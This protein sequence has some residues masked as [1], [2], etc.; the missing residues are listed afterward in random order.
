MSTANTTT[1]FWPIDVHQAGFIYGWT[2]PAL[3]IAGVIQSD[4]ESEAMSKLDSI[5]DTTRWKPLIERWGGRPFVLGRCSFAERV[6]TRHS[7]PGTLPHPILEIRSEFPKSLVLT[8]LSQLQ[9]IYYHRH[10]ATSMRLYASEFPRSLFALQGRS[11][12]TDSHKGHYTNVKENADTTQVS[13]SKLYTYFLLN[14]WNSAKSLQHS[15]DDVHSRNPHRHPS[16]KYSTAWTKR[17]RRFIS[18]VSSYIRGRLN[19]IS[20][21]SLPSY[22]NLSF[23][24]QQLDVRAGTISSLF[25]LSQTLHEQSSA[26]TPSSSFLYIKFY[27]SVWVILNDITVGM[28][29]GTFLCKNRMV[30]AAHLTHVME[31]W[32]VQW[33]Q[34]VLVWLDSWPAG[35]K[36]NTELGRFY[37]HTL[38]GLIAVWN[39]AFQQT[40]PLL[41]GTIGLVGLTSFLGATLAISLAS[42]LLCVLTAHMYVCYRL[43]A[44]VYYHQLQLVGSLWKLFR[45]KRYNALRNRTDT[46][47]YDIDQLLLGTILFT[48]VAYLSPTITLYYALF[49]LLRLSIVFLHAILQTLLAFISHFPLFALM[50]RVKDPWRVPGGI[51]LSPQTKSKSMQNVLVVENCPPTLSAIFFQYAELWTWLARHYHPIQLLR[52]IVTGAFLT[53]VTGSF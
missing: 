7:S 18:T 27:N 53:V 21:A 3:C 12:S 13:S 6:V 32:S 29:L 46:W 5:Q 19:V 47:D 39:T 25:S 23:T 22:R 17:P 40:A 36:L 35:L 16:S 31:T 44:V 42:D 26:V 51:Y 38:I 28:A 43:V 49:A 33:L 1:I 11:S 2:T 4:Q 9:F 15:M 37:S 30:L 50:L 24:A 20:S 34:R 41:P 48:L 8:N 14:Q 52:C 45:G 10:D